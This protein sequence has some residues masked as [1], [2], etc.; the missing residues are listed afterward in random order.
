VLF[1]LASVEPAKLTSTMVKRVA[2]ELTAFFSNDGDFKKSVG[3]GTNGK[4]ATE[5]RL[6]RTRD[7]VKKVVG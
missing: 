2:A 6:T 4:G 7:V 3:T 5:Y 1:A